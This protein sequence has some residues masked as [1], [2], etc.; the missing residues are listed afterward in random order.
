MENIAKKLCYSCGIDIGTKNLAMCFFSGQ[1]MIGYRGDISYLNRYE[2]DKPVQK[3]CG[4]LQE[5]NI[6][7]KYQCLISLLRKIPEFDNCFLI[8]IEKQLPLHNAEMLRI[9]GIIFGYLS[10]LSSCT[11]VQYISS[12][13]RSN[14]SE[15]I[16]KKFEDCKKTIIKKK[17]SKEQKIAGI[18]ITGYFFPEFYEKLVETVED[19]KLDDICDCVIYCLID[20]QFDPLIDFSDG[21]IEKLLKKN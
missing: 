8:N 13:T 10:T 2:L 3:I 20:S 18:Q 4:D 17:P 9:D 21:N 7:S 16:L 15:N 14:Y 1:R 19:E 5:E 11:K 6:S 12:Q